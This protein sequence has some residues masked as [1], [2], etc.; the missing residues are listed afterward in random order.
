MWPWKLR[1]RKN[2]CMCIVWFGVC[3]N[4]LNLKEMCQAQWQC[5]SS[6][7]D[8]L[9]SECAGSWLICP[10][11]TAKVVVT[12]YSPKDPL[13]AIIKAGNRCLLFSF[14]DFIYIKWA[15]FSRWWRM[16]KS[17]FICKYIYDHTD[18]LCGACLAS[19]CPCFFPQ[20]EDVDVHVSV[21]MCVFFRC[22]II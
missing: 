6:H 20:S 19:L 17:N 4:G 3:V 13:H 15:Q 22:Q 14:T 2:G 10:S 21:N 12:S 16:K 9:S 18:Y 5:Y 11:F 1:Y 8:C 7:W